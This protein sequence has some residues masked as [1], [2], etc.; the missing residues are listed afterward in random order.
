V[1]VAP[2]A[3]DADVRT[4]VDADPQV[5]DALTGRTVR[6]VIVR[7]PKLVNFVVD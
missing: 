6:R 1:E 4:A 3:S 5:Q 7:A 2:D